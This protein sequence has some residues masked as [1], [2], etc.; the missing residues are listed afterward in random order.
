MLGTTTPTS[1]RSLKGALIFTIPP[2]MWYYLLFTILARDMDRR[3]QR[4]PLGPPTIIALTP[5]A[6]DTTSKFI[7]SNYNIQEQGER[8]PHESAD[9]VD[10]W[11][12][13]YWPRFHSLQ[14]L[15]CPKTNSG[16]ITMLQISKYQ[17]QIPCLT[18]P[19]MSWYFLSSLYSHSNK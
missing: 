8:P 18:D 9:P 1:L 3:F 13:G 4:L 17:C 19:E 11:Q 2:L 14:L 15:L 10:P 12:A 7:N 6:K 16:T 5:Q